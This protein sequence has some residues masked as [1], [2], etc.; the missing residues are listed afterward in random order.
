ML[1]VINDMKR[2]VLVVMVMSSAIGPGLRWSSAVVCAPC[3]C[4]LE[5]AGL[6]N[7]PV[8]VAEIDQGLAHSLCKGI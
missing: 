2:L 6:N 4:G 3:S 7:T 5:Q 1:S 8:R